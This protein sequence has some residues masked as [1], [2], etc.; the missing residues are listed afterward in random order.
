MGTTSLVATGGS[1][2]AGGVVAVVTIVGLV[3]AQTSAS[4]Q[5]PTD[6]SQPVSIDYGTT[7]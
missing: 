4:G 5:S 7:N 6:V 3:N 1:L 2:I